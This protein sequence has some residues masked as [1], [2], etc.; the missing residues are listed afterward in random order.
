M[1]MTSTGLAKL[2]GVSRATVDRVFNNRGYVGEET[3]RKVLEAAEAAGY[4]PNHVAHSLVTGRTQSIGVVLPGLNNHFFSTLLNAAARRAQQSGYIA[5]VSLYEDGPGFEYKCVQNLADRQAD[6]F[7][8]F[9]TDK[10]GSAARLL[11]E[12]G[13]PAVAILNEA[14]S[15]PFVS[16]DYCAAM[17]D[18]ANYAV[19]KGYEKLVFLC[20]PLEYEKNS[21]I[22]AIRR[23]LAGFERAMSLHREVE[24]LVIGSSDYLERLGGMAFGAGPKTAILCSSDIYALKTLRLLKSRGVRVPYDV[25]VMGFDG[26]DVLDYVEPSV[27]T[28]S[29]PI[30]RLGEAAVNRLLDGI[31]GRGG[32]G[33]TLLP[34]RIKPGQSI[35]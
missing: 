3:R 29:I 19:S 11:A 21:N 2:C 15:L 33:E 28:V 26:I 16:I 27:A 17:F 4:S 14:G 5:L 31:E 30:E 35:V 32:E 7:I 10:E 1:R 25:G 8:L 12:R 20:P 24:S 13:I 34:Y 18:A 6:G 22:F 9:S 23:R